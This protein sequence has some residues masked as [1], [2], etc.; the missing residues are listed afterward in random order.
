MIRGGKK[1]GIKRTRGLWVVEEQKRDNEVLSLVGKGRYI[2]KKYIYA[3]LTID[4]V[5]QT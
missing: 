1:W 4:A 3:K 2:K 5:K